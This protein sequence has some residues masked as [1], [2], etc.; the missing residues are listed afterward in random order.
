MS[1]IFEQLAAPFP[2]EAVQWRPQTVRKDRNGQHWALALAYIDSR[3]VQ[4]RLDTVVGPD[5]WQSEH[6]DAGGGRL[7]CKIGLNIHVN[8]A[9]A[10][11]D[12][13]VEPAPP[14]WVW[15]SDG[16]GATQVEAE[17]GAFSDAFKRAAVHWG[18]GRYLY[19]LGNTWVPCD[20]YEKNKK[21]HFKAFTADPWSKVK[22]ASAF[23]PKM[24]DAA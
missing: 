3:D 20:A 8:K 13:A 6:F 22:N 10:R 19:D 12:G 15:K 11:G 24:E 16:A 5:G 2:A 14:L 17:K 7:G 23:L 4:D 9:Q 21:P 18:I 1:D